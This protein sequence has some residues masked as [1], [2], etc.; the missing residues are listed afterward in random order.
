MNKKKY[1]ILLTV[2]LFFFYCEREKSITDPVT[3]EPTTLEGKLAGV[4]PIEDS[5][6]IVT[7][8]IVVDSLNELTIEPG[9]QLFFKLG[10]YLSIYGI[11]YCQGTAAQ[12]IIFKRNSADS[13]WRGIHIIYSPV[14]SYFKH[15]VVEGVRIDWDDSLDFGALSLTS[16]DA[17]IENCIFRENYAQNGGAIAAS[18]STLRIENSLFL[19]ND[20]VVYGGAVFSLQCSTTFINNTVYDNNCTNVGGGVVIYDGIYGNI[21]NNIFYQN[22]GQQGDP[23]IYLDQ[24]DSALV[25]VTFNFLL[26]DSLQPGFI[27]TTK[28]NQDFHLIPGSVCMDTGN[29]APQFNDPDGSRNDQGA[30]GGPGGN[31]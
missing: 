9:V 30:Y 4:L 6:Y 20:C 21:Q 28:P 5:P 13:A 14:S 10:T 29:P 25:T 2:F 26:G 22:T 23:R 11:L 3:V 8:D 19:E 17:I 24:T 27:S 31:W 7:G 12:P 18:N 15:I 16:S 1:F